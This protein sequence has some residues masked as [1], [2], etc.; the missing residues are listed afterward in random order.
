MR[1][2]ICI[3][4]I[5][6]LIMTMAVGA[7]ATTVFLD[8]G[9]QES[10]E[11]GQ[12]IKITVKVKEVK[13][14]IGYQFEISFD[15][16]TLKLLSIAESNFLKEDGSSTLPLVTTTT[17]KSA[18][19]DTI[20]AEILQDINVS[21]AFIVANLRFG[22]NVKG[23]DG[24]GDLITARFTVLEAKESKIDIKNA[25]GD[26]QKNP[27]LVN[28][29]TEF[30]VTDLVG[31]TIKKKEPACVK[32]D[33]NGDGKIMA[34]DAIL[35]LRISA[36]LME[37]TDQQFCAADMNNNG[38]IQ[39]NDAILILNK[40]VGAGAPPRKE[41]FAIKGVA[42]VTLDEVN[43]IAGNS[44]LVPIRIN[45]LDLVTGGDLVINYDK[46]V[47]RAI[48][49]ISEP[50]VM[51]A[52]NI[53]EPGALR[54]SFLNSEEFKNNK[55]ADIKFEI[56]SDNISHLVLKNVDLYQSDSQPI[57]VKKIDGIFKSWAL[58][59]KENALLQN[60]PNPF[61]PDT[62]IPFQLKEDGNVLIR[63]YSISG[64]LV[65]E[66]NLG[67][68]PAGIYISKDRS[69]YWDGRDKFGMPVASGIYFYNLKV[70]DFSETKKLIVI[71]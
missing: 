14:L 65:R 8:P 38:K 2:Y 48:D 58:P 61:N 29:N 1:T 30:I 9:V 55:L 3:V 47:L 18:T 35:V 32:G 26:I 12:E 6:I 45:N 34:N 68:K 40:I 44:I 37:P 41:I 51:I 70:N 56:I 63:I 31:A 67:Y 53:K 22:A 49:V 69:V 25:F 20:N 4:A 10:P 42:E 13:D 28:S 62:W 7:N 19:F 27:V 11:I 17:G 24:D 64:E 52:D 66:I 46:S 59:A 71:K 54:I 43:G 36:Q 50:N 5:F 23:V 15:K 16:S 33:V 60:F 39:A 57:N 21:G